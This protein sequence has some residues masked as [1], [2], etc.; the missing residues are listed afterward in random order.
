LIS[1]IRVSSD[2][3]VSFFNHLGS[4]F[5][6]RRTFHKLGDRV[7]REFLGKL[8]DP[9]FQ[10]FLL[11]PLFFKS[12]IAVAARNPVKRLSRRSCCLRVLRASVSPQRDF[13][14]QF[15]SDPA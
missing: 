5:I 2:L 4:E 3:T 10:L 8:R 13:A 7:V 12:G 15:A 6:D 11:R 1:W 14:E 9:G